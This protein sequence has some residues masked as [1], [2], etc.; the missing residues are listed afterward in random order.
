MQEKTRT[1]TYDNRHSSCTKFL[2]RVLCM[3][4]FH[5]PTSEFYSVLFSESQDIAASNVLMYTGKCTISWV[6]QWW[7]R[8]QQTGCV[9]SCYKFLVWVRS[10]EELMKVRI[11]E[12]RTKLDV[13]SDIDDVLWQYSY[14]PD[15]ADWSREMRG[16]PLL[17]SIPLSS[18][19]MISTQRDQGNATDLF[20]NL[21]KVC[22]GMGMPIDRPN[23]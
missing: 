17:N 8:V 7:N 19:I 5:H 10:Y 3:R 14:R 2:V 12:L 18:W 11:G 20:S 9:T 4:N 6:Y 13:I 15:N 23:V 16:Q 22:S 21:Q 1:K